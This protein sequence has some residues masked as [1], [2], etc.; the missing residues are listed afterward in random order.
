MLTGQISAWRFLIRSFFY[1]GFIVVEVFDKV[2]SLRMFGFQQQRLQK[3][4][5][6]VHRTAGLVDQF[7]EI[8]DP[9]KRRS[10]LICNR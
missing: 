8:F 10:S 9:E 7:Q 6:G 1:A 5:L 2:F 3:A 4:T